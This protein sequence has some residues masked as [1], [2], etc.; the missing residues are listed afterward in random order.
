M[1]SGASIAVLGTSPGDH[2]QPEAEQLCGKGEFFRAAYRGSSCEGMHWV[3]HA[4]R[5]I[6]MKN[7][8]PASKGGLGF[9][10]PLRVFEFHIECSAENILLVRLSLDGSVPFQ[11]PLT[12]DETYFSD[13]PFLVLEMNGTLFGEKMCLDGRDRLTGTDHSE[14]P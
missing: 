13:R 2:G 11:S 14:I 7:F 10:Y 3:D 6:V 4:N 8:K 9:Q 1:V 12:T 5:A